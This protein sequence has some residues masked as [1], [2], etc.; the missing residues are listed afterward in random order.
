MSAVEVVCDEAALQAALSYI[1]HIG[2]EEL[3]RPQR[4]S[5][6]LLAAVAE[7][8]GRTARAY[9][10]ELAAKG[11]NYKSCASLLYQLVERG[12]LR[13]GDDPHTS[14]FYPVT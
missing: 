13:A 8:P 7:N 12:H 3:I 5:E 4:P 9:A 11:Y 1:L 2:L 10:H 14:T 6:A